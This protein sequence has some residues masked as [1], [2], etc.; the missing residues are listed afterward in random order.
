MSLKLSFCPHETFPPFLSSLF[1]PFSLQE[2]QTTVIHNPVDG[3]KVH[4]PPLPS[5]SLF[6]VLFLFIHHPRLHPFS[7]CVNKAIFGKTC[8]LEDSCISLNIFTHLC[9]HLFICLFVHEEDGESV[10]CWSS[11]RV[12]GCV[13]LPLC[14]QTNGAQ[15]FLLLAEQSMY[16]SRNANQ[17]NPPPDVRTVC[18]GG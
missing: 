11:C 7:L 13:I 1:S 17:I 2:P 14:V 10:S 5:T 8:F 15:W 6:I 9:V 12:F 3:T 4:P 18:D 16:V